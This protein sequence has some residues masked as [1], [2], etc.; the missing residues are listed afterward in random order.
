MPTFAHFEILAV[1]VHRV[2]LQQVYI[3]LMLNP[4][5]MAGSYGQAPTTDEVQLI[6][7]LTDP[8]HGVIALGCLS[9]SASSGVCFR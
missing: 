9:V 8:G 1:M 5:R 6:I 4:S 3:N 7:S 2:E